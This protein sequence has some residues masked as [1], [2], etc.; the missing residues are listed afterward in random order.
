MGNHYYLWPRLTIGKDVKDALD[1]ISEAQ[2]DIVG[3][4]D[5]IVAALAEARSVAAD[6]AVEVQA[7]LAALADQVAVL[8]ATVDELTAGQVTQEEIDAVSELVA[9]LSAEI[10]AIDTSNE[11]DFPGEPMPEEPEPEP[12]EPVEV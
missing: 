8:Q 4:L 5:T 9:D 3:R 11:P 6:E 10:E 7:S 1:E 2:E 12:E